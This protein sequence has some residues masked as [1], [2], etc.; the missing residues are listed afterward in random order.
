MFVPTLE[1]NPSNLTSVPLRRTTLGLEVAFLL[2]LQAKTTVADTCQSLYLSTD[3]SREL[4]SNYSNVI[5]F[6]STFNTFLT[7]LA[8]HLSPVYTLQTS[9][10]STRVK[11]NPG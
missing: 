3:D 6:L 8:R 5:L 1:S 10:G 9:P 7:L 2:N 4:H 11:T